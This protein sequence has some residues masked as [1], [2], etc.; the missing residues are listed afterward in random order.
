MPAP[1]VVYAAQ[2]GAVRTCAQ[3]RVRGEAARSGL[4]QGAGE[5]KAKRAAGTMPTTPD[6]RRRGV[7]YHS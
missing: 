1:V 2:V 5:G 6:L 3:V 4:C 7:A